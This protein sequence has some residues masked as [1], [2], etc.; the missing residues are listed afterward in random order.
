VVIPVKP[1]ETVV[2]P[3]ET[4]VA[5]MGLDLPPMAA[6]VEAGP[7]SMSWPNIN[8]D[9]IRINYGDK[10]CTIMFDDSVFSYWT[11]ISPES[12]V[13]LGKL[14]N[15]LR[16]NMD[17]YKLIIEGHTDNVPLSS[18]SRYSSNYELGMARAEAVYNL[19]SKQYKM[20]TD[21]MLPTSAGQ[22]KPPYSNAD[23]TSRRKNRTVVMEIIRS[24]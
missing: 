6:P 12:I 11:T 8:V 22:K 19:L 9:G 5:D 13:A 4:A 18:N 16:G 15:Q 20:P 10:V 2:K 14:A 7:S 23:A 1:V 24:D 21:V 17:R 3:V